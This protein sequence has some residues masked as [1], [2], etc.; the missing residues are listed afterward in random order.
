VKADKS[1]LTKYRETRI[2]SHPRAASD[3]LGRLHRVVFVLLLGT[4]LVACGGGDDSA[5]PVVGQ[6]P[7]RAAATRTLNPIVGVFGGSLGDDQG[8]D[9]LYVVREDGTKVGYFGTDWT[10]SF[11]FA[12]YWVSHDAAWSWQSLDGT[13]SGTF[14]GAYR[15][16]P[17]FV[18]A[19]F[20]M[21]A[22]RLSGLITAGMLT[23]K[24]VAFGGGAI[25]GSSYKFDTPAFVATVAGRWELVDDGGKSVA[26]DIA[27]DGG[28]QGN[29][30]GCS[31]MGSATPS[32]RGGNAL[33]SISNCIARLI[34]KPPATTASAVSPL[35]FQ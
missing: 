4:L 11:K 3:V 28:V 22:P 14:N 23:T 18:S 33:I 26:I 5:S 34:P 10:N 12:G 8:Y 15:G 30:Q 6:P 9:L 1:D 16:E 31:V 35:H 20:D 19:T 13:R 24:T 17:A 25:P 29:Y 2:T 27:S 7:A 32:T 21:V